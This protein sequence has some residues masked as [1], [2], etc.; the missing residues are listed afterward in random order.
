MLRFT[1]E[2]IINNIDSSFLTD[3]SISVSCNR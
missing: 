1:L 3:N 2:I